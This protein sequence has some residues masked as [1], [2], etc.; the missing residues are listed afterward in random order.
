VKRHHDQGNSYQG[1]QFPRFCP[2]SPWQEAW[3]PAVDLVLEKELRVLCLDPKAARRRLS[4]T[5]S[6]EESLFHTGQSLAIGLQSP[7]PQWLTSSNKATPTPIRPYLLTVPLPTG[8]AYSN[9]HTNQPTNQDKA[10]C[11][12]GR[13]IIESLAEKAIRSKQVSEQHSSMASASSPASR[14]LP[15]LS[16]CLGS[17]WG[18]QDRYVK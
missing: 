17:F 5:G 16:S 8:Q 18:I 1:K 14:L 7:S 2:L 13:Y 10:E 3:Y 4:S 15:S 6:R 11:N 12:W 9:H